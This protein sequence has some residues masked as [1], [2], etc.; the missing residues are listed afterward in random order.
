MS[1]MSP[2]SPDVYACGGKPG[3]GMAPQELVP[4]PKPVWLLC[5]EGTSRYGVL[6][7]DADAD[8]EGV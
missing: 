4:Y 6:E 8:A 2:S 7:L 5:E 3:E 1:Y